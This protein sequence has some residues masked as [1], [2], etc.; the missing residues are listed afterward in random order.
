MAVNETVVYE[1]PGWVDPEGN[2]VAEI[3]VAPMEGQ[4]TK[5]PPFLSFTNSSNKL[6]FRPIDFW[7][8]G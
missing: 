7:T 5:Y 2:D 3:Y 6:D 8:S 4:E 1:L